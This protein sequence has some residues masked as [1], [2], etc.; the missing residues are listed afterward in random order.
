[1]KNKKYTRKLKKKNKN[2]SFKNINKSYEIKQDVF[3]K[4]VFI[5]LIWKQVIESV[6]KLNR[7]SDLNI[8]DPR[9]K[10]FKKEYKRRLSVELKKSKKS[11]K[12]YAK[13]LKISN[14][15]KTIKRSIE[16]IPMKKLEDVY[17]EILFKQ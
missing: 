12:I 9:R 5:P 2:R 16:K 6:D 1:M 11:R 7:G 14:N 15:A 4:R 10:W 17:Y 13:K 3:G 8:K